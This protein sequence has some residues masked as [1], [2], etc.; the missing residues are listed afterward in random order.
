MF[1]LVRSRMVADTWYDGAC[2]LYSRRHVVRWSIR[3]VYVG[4]IENSSRH[5]IR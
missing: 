1:M 5:V 4:K 2:A 3:I